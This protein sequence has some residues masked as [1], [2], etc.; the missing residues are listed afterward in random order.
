VL[1]TKRCYDIGNRLFPLLTAFYR[2]NPEAAAAFD[3][4]YPQRVL[5]GGC[6]PRRS[7]AAE[8]KF[9]DQKFKFFWDW[10]W[11]LSRLPELYNIDIAL[12]FIFERISN[13]RIVKK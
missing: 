6:P 5:G 7:I 4:Q 10:L 11:T 12:A 13:T 3:L 1:A 8:P 9:A 2:R